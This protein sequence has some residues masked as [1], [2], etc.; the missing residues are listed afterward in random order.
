[1][2]VLLVV[3]CVLVRV[4]VGREARWGSEEIFKGGDVDHRIEYRE[5]SRS[6]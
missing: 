4:T 6:R 3:D 2:A 5:R 1:V